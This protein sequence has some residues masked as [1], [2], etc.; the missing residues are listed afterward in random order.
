M[1]KNTK[2]Y[3]AIIKKCINKKGQIDKSRAG[4]VLALEIALAKVFYMVQD[5]SL[6]KKDLHKALGVK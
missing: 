3:V 6:K 5:G 2:N 1:D 4:D